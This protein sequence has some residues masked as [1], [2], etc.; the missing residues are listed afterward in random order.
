[1]EQI[2]PFDTSRYSAERAAIAA[3]RVFLF[4]GKWPH[5]LVKDHSPHIWNV[6]LS[7]D[8]ATLVRLS[9]ESHK[10][11]LGN[12]LQ[13]LKEITL[14]HPNEDPKCLSRDDISEVRAWLR[15]EGVDSQPRFPRR[16]AGAEDGNDANGVPSVGASMIP[17]GT[18]GFS[19]IASDSS[20]DFDYYSSDDEEAD[21][22]STIRIK[23]EDEAPVAPRPNPV[24]RPFSSNP[25]SSRASEPGPSASLPPSRPTARTG[26]TPSSNTAPST[27]LRVSDSVN[28]HF[29]ESLRRAAMTNSAS[30][31]R[32]QASP[33]RSVARPNNTSQAGPSTPS[34]TTPNHQASP[35][36]NRPAASEPRRDASSDRSQVNQSTQNTSQQQPSAT[37]NPTRLNAQ[38]SNN[39]VPRALNTPVASASSS[40][41]ASSPTRA[42]EPRSATNLRTAPITDVPTGSALHRLDGS[43]DS[44]RTTSTHARGNASS[45][46]SLETG[47]SGISTPNRPDVLSNVGS[48]NS[49]STPTTARPRRDTQPPTRQTHDLPLSAVLNPDVSRKR[50][51]ESTT[52]VTYQTLERPGASST[53]P[54]TNLG[55]S[56]ERP[57]QAGTGNTTRVNAA[58]SSQPAP[59]SR[60]QAPNATPTQTNCSWT[61]GNARKRQRLNDPTGRSISLDDISDFDATLPN[62]ECFKRHLREW[63]AWAEPHAKNIDQKLVEIVGQIHSV[64]NHYQTNSAKRENAINQIQAAKQSLEENQAVITKNR[65]IIAVLEEESQGDVLAQEYLDKRKGLLKEHE[66]VHR[67]FQH[68]LTSAQTVLEEIDLQ[69]PTLETK[70]G[71]LVEDESTLRKKKKSL[72]A[73]IKKWE[74]Q[75]DLM[76]ADGG[77]AKAMGRWS[78]GS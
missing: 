48:T 54:G 56:N 6:K 40:N 26:T 25:S 10:V 3:R 47:I 23:S 7:E 69:H 31:P 22:P 44:Y 18:S 60:T 62:G 64:S 72:S 53:A 61:I 46:A 41:V 57:P 33:S 63:Y 16:S 70:L 35:S 9:V 45:S 2:T 34:R 32:P 11:E 59:T 65:K 36:L 15:T 12:V 37:V 58:S 1:M 77:W 39:P 50:P 28:A 27:P 43:F 67:S 30:R 42:R 5:E 51:L 71:E 49:N 74:F 19:D 21:E 55:S 78:V 66:L 73:A 8:F 20:L 4:S 52:P 76:E 29:Q 38:A 13:R 14:K 17:A 24:T 68:E 75:T